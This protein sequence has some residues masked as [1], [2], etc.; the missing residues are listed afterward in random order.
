MTDK[1]YMGSALCAVDSEGGIILPPFIR[2]PLALRSNEAAILVGGHETDV[3][4][5][6]YDPARAIELQADCRRRRIAEEGSKPGASHARE[7][8]LFGLLHSLPVDGD[9]RVALPG[10]L[11]RRAR[12]RDSVLVVGTGENFEIWGLN[13]A[14]Y[15]HDVSMRALASLS[16]E[17]NQAA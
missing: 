6:G 16:L 3:C 9:G 8:R 15:G 1:M 4:L 5:A 12:I 2:E 7:R 17:I 10:L 14:L 13:V 11:R